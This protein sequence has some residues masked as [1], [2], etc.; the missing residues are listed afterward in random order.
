[1]K[2]TWEMMNRWY[3]E[4]ILDP[5]FGTRT[6]DDIT[7]LMINNEL[8][9]SFGG[10]ST[11]DWRLSLG[12][13][14]N[15][16]AEFIAY[17]IADA[18]G[19]VNCTHENAANNYVVVRKDFEHPEAAVQIMNALFDDLM[20]L[21]PE[22]APEVYQFIADGGD[23]FCRPFQLEVLPIDNVGKYW[24]DHYGV[25]TGAITPEEC[26][27]SENRSTTSAMLEYLAWAED[28]DAEWTSDVFGGWTKYTSRIVGCGAAV[29]ALNKNGNVNWTTPLYPPT[30]PIRE[31]KMESLNTLRL[32]AY[33]KIVTGE[34]DIS[35]YDTFKDEWYANG[36]TEILAE[37]SDYYANK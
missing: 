22:S 7:S 14:Q 27:T 12:K 3:E 23:N 18:E 26:Q 10:W 5:Q 21:T 20:R 25:M 33:V 37:L 36:G 15:P 1:M 30:L 16:E 6:Y 24:D 9:I 34:E 32:Q 8:G 29:D 17:T 19:K 13:D 28:P 2:E 35:Y 11:P 31:Q 4:G